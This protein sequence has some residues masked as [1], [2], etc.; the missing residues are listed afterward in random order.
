MDR[1]VCQTNLVSTSVGT[2]ACHKVVLATFDLVVAFLPRGRGGKL[3]QIAKLRL[4][5]SSACF[6]QPQT[7]RPG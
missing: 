1:L 2:I 5:A 3:W 4:P 6:F 7:V